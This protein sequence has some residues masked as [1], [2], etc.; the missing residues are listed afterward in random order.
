MKPSLIKRKEYTKP[1]KKTYILAIITGF[2][3][4]LGAILQQI[5]LNLTKA[6]KFQVADGLP[7][8]LVVVPVYYLMGAI[9]LI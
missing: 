3:L 8:F 9:G 5:G 7:A 1:T 4:S 6:V 2:A